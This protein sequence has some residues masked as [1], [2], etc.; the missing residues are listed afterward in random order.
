[1]SEEKRLFSP[2]RLSVAPYRNSNGSHLRW[3]STEALFFL[4]LVNVK[5]ELALTFM[6]RA[7]FHLLPLLYLRA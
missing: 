7:T 3:I 4:S 2:A 6:L 5:V 1:M